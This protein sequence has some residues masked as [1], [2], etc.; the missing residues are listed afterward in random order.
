MEAHS[1]NIMF[2]QGTLE[3]ALALVLDAL[4]GEMY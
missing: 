1:S 3:I 2:V 4:K